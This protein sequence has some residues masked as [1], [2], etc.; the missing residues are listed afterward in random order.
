[1]KGLGII[2]AV[3]ILVCC[4][5]M[6]DIHAAVTTSGGV[7]VGVLS[8]YVWR[9]VKLSNSYVVQPSVSVGYGGLN[10]GFRSNW[11]SD[12]NDRGEH[13]ETDFSL[14]QSFSKDNKTFD[15][16]YIYYAR[17]GSA[18]DTQEIYFA[19]GLQG[20]ITSGIVLYYDYDK[21]D[22]MF[23]TASIGQTLHYGAIGYNLTLSASYNYENTV[24][25]TN[26]A[27]DEFKDLYNGEM[28]ASFII[29]ISKAVKTTLRI[30]YSVPLSNNAEEAIESLSDDGNA[31]IV[32]GGVIMSLGF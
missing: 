18:N 14:N 20:E 32:Y 30:A 2:F 19:V 28:A 24:M 7:S 12:R 29:P 9:G 25:G 27:G 5:P 23:A 21:G 3:Y 16:G 4:F 31:K 17:E 15:T 22:G 6:A 1:M 26:D 10:A 8:N 11:D 13:T